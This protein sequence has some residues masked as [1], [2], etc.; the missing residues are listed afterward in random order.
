LT[1]HRILV[2]LLAVTLGMGAAQ[3]QQQQQQQTRAHDGYWWT[4]SSNEFRLGFVWG[5]VMAMVTAADANTFKCLAEKNGGKL[6][7]KLCSMDVLDACA[8]GPDV[9][10]FD[11]GGHFRMGQWLD[12]VD[13]F[14]KDFR[15]KGLDV[16]LAMRYVKE[17]LHGK[18]AKE[19]E[20]EVTEWRRSA[21]K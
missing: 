21:A 6:P 9:V 12:G 3:G 18:P 14:Y 13:E 20:D 4:G 15:N 1:N 19:L 16:Q 2:V 17:Q 11:F 8:R 7:E 5:Y 10:P